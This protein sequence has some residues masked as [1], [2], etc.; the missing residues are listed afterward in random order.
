MPTASAHLAAALELLDDPALS[1]SQQLASGE[2][3]GAFMLGNFSPDVRVINGLAR[4]ITHFYDIPL[5]PGTSASHALLNTH[6]EL[7]KG[8]VLSANQAAFVAGYM[9]HLIMD[10]AWLEFV[11]MPYIFIDDAA[12]D[13]NHPNYRLYSLLMTYLAEQGDRQVPSD[14]ADTLR[15]VE[16]NNWLPFASDEHLVEW[17]E[18]VIQYA[19]TDGGWRTAKMFAHQ[20]G[21][22]ADELY[23]VVTSQEAMDREVFSVMPREKLETFQRSTHKRSIKALNAYLVSSAP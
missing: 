2:P 11:V 6:P 12:W 13:T 17:R 18:R 8:D 9:A 16:P 15:A 19:L 22:N 1:A 5:S 3:H 23:A 14:M 10:E 20:M 21:S 4:E 7:A